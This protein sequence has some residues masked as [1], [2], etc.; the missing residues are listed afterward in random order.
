MIL[1]TPLAEFA[2]KFDPTG[3]FSYLF[4]TSPRAATR[5]LPRERTS[6][7][8]LTVVST[9]DI[10]NVM[11]LI[12]NLLFISSWVQVLKVH[13]KILF[14]LI[15]LICIIGVYSLNSVSDVFVAFVLGIVG[16]L[17]RKLGYIAFPAVTRIDCQLSL[18][19]KPSSGLVCLKR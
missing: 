11:F 7:S 13:Y 8:F 18:R 16:R 4:R 17:F 14:P 15:V 10:G 12:L 3:F 9:M 2:L 5:A 1:V 19:I 6:R